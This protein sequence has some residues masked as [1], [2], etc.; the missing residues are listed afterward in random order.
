MINRVLNASTIFS[1]EKYDR[2]FVWYI[3]FM[4]K[5]PSLRFM[6]GFSCVTRWFSGG[7][8]LGN[9]M[10]IYFFNRKL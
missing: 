8:L 10:V 4:K 6:N 2:D 3:N 1:E 9:Y 7:R 5:I